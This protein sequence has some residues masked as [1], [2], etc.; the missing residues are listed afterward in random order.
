[1]KLSLEKI[2]YIAANIKILTE[3]DI[4]AT[5]AYKIMKLTR[6]LSEELKTLEELRLALVKKYANDGADRV[7]EENTEIATRDKTT[8]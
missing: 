7:S 2:H 3:K 1:M 8:R 4:P 5:K 6:M